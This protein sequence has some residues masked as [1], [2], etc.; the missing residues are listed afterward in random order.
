MKP[1]LSSDFLCHT[2][3]L[4]PLYKIEVVVSAQELYPS[5][6]PRP[7][8]YETHY[9]HRDYRF[10]QQPWHFQGRWHDDKIIFEMRYHSLSPCP[11]L[12][13]HTHTH[14]SFCSFIFTLHLCVL[15]CSHLYY[16]ISLVV[17]HFQFPVPLLQ[18]S[19]IIFLTLVVLNLK[20]LFSEFGFLKYTT[21]FYYFFWGNTNCQQPIKANCPYLSCCF[22]PLSQSSVSV[23]HC[24]S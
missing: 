19:L 8:C 18:L 20:N 3:T 22:S 12:P 6:S 13:L 10:P 16:F 4:V 14:T 9:H 7:M 23:S 11:P 1:G 5:A 24:T 15:S 17:V 2:H 21:Y